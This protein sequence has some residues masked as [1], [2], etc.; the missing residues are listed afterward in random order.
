[1]S[2]QLLKIDLY[3]N[4]EYYELGILKMGGD[5]LSISIGNKNFLWAIIGY[6]PKP[7]KEYD[8]HF[9]VNHGMKELETKQILD[10]FTDIMYK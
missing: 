1:M 10:K 9:I 5:W 2:K 4:N 7:N 8:Y 6:T 3:H